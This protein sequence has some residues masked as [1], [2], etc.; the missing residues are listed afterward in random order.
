L[1]TPFDAPTRAV[2]AT[3]EYEEWPRGRIVFNFAAQ[4]F[5]VYADRQA[6]IYGEKIRE[7]FNL[8][9]DAVFRTDL[10]YRSTKHLPQK[11]SLPVSPNAGSRL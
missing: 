11:R 10:H 6:F 5:V 9:D 2:I 8:P 1:L 7:T 3:S 4:R